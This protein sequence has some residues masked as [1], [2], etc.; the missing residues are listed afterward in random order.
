LPACWGA[1]GDLCRPSPCLRDEDQRPGERFL[2]GCHVDA[3]VTGP[4][5]AIE[6]PGAG[7]PRRVRMA[8]AAD[9]GNELPNK[10][11]VMA[12]VPR[13]PAPANAVRVR[14]LWRCLR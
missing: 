5:G 4:S 10:T 7:R 1:G 6:D 13:I 11:A 8:G 3:H 12:A 2:V 14:C 9:A